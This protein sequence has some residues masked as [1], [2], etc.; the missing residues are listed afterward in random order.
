MTKREKK[1]YLDTFLD[2][3]SEGCDVMIDSEMDLKLSKDGHPL[4]T[5]AVVMEEAVKQIA[6][7]QNNPLPKKVPEKVSI[8]L[9]TPFNEFDSDD[10]DG[11][12]VKHTV[13]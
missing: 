11:V 10:L 3:V 9:K 8:D 7:K 12:K 13:H 1:E 2:A 5:L 4:I 6:E